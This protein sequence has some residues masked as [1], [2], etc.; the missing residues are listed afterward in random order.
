MKQRAEDQE[1]TR[2][3]IVEAAVAL[4][5][6]VGPKNT[7][8]SAV[9]KKAGVQ[10]LTVY[11]HF[12]DEESLFRACSMHWLQANPPPGIGVWDSEKDARQ[13]TSSIVHAL[14]DY[15]RQTSSMWR[16]VYRDIDQVPAMQ[17]PLDDF[18][19]YLAA[20][21]D[22]LIACWQPRGRKSPSLKATVRHV[23]SYSTWESLSEQKLTDKQMADLGLRWIAA[24]HAAG[25]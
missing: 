19:E 16:L 22:T 3:K 17:A 21:C 23:L 10:R 15:Y 9:A 8:I 13:K 24:I 12:P 5:G 6:T 2:E 20:I 1:R 7:S 14:F 11:R 18:H 4:H 25:P